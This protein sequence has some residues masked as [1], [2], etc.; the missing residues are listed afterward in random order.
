MTKF[1]T[2]NIIWEILF[3]RVSHLQQ[4]TLPISYDFGSS[5]P[6]YQRVWLPESLVLRVGTLMQGSSFS[7]LI[8]AINKILSCSFNVDFN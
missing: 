3:H 2:K 5:Y 6:E 7:Y 8:D 4:S 1:T